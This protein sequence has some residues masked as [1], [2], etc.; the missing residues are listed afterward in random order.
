M[1]RAELLR[2][3]LKAKAKPQGHCPGAFLLDQTLIDYAVIAFRFL[4]PEVLE[5]GRER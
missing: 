3:A 1:T 2:H 5:A 4:R